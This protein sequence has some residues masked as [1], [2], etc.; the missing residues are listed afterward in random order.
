M[1]FS[2]LGIV[3]LIF[4]LPSFGVVIIFESTPI[5]NLNDKIHNDN[6]Y[7]YPSNFHNEV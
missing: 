4:C 1:G 2:S 7:G 5:G 6:R 3:M